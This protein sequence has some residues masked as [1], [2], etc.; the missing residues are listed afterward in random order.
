[1]KY[2]NIAISGDIGTGKTTLAKKLA[3]KLNWKHT[4]AGD[5]FRAW[6]QEN[7]IPLNE[8]EKIPPEKDKEMDYGFQN[9]MK[10]EKQ[11]IFESRLAGYLAKDLEDVFKILC[12]AELE[13]AIQRAGERDQ[14]S[15]DEAKSNVSIRSKALK[16]KFKKLYDVD[17]YLDP[18]Y[19][20]LVINSTT[21]SP[22]E[23]LEIV[24]K[25][26]ENNL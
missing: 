24:L 8:T 7:N 9:L 11:T 26:L 18:K 14:V 13:V 25:K 10:N 20:N 6:H 19:F 3:Q 17:D 23:N 21:N 5:Y 1:M 12:T 16:E 4:N 15:E 22:D 2:K